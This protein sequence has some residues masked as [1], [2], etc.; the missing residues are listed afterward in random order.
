MLEQNKFSSKKFLFI[1]HNERLKNQIVKSLRFF[2]DEEELKLVS[3]SV[4][5]VKD[6]LSKFIGDEE[7]KSCFNEEKRLNRRRFKKLFAGKEIDIDLF[8]E[9]YRGILRGYNLHGTE[10]ILEEEIY[11]DE[12]GRR[13]GKVDL[14]LRE[15]FY[16]IAS[17]IERNLARTEDLD[18][19][20]GG[21]DDLD[22]CRYLEN[23]IHSGEVERCLD[24][25]YIDEVQDLTTAELD[26]FLQLL[27]PNGIQWF[28]AAGDLSQSVQPSAFTWE[29]LR[30][31]ITRI[32]GI[33]VREEY[34]LDENYRSTPHLVNA[35]NRILDISKEYSGQNKAHLQRPTKGENEGEPMYIFEKSEDE[36]LKMLE[37]HKL[38]NSDCLLLTRDE[39]TKRY[40]KSKMSEDQANFIETIARYKGLEDRDVI[41]W[42]PCSGSE[43]ILDLL[44]HPQRGE[45]MMKKIS[46]ITSG[47]LELNFLF[48]AL[49]RARYLLG[50]CAPVDNDRQHFLKYAFSSKDYSSFDSGEKIQTFGSMK[51]DR[52][53]YLNRAISLIE[54]GN[55]SAAS[56]TYR[57]IGMLHEYH[58]YKAEAYLEEEDYPRAVLEWSKTIESGET[59][60][61]TGRFKVDAQNQ[62][63]EY[64]TE[65]IEFSTNEQLDD[66]KVCIR[67][68][69]Y[70]I[71]PDKSRNKFKG[72]D[73]YERGKFKD[74]AQ[75]YYDADERD[76]VNK[77]LNKFAAE[78]A[79][80]KIEL[81]LLIDRIDEAEK[82]FKKLYK[83]KE[84]K[85]PGIQLALMSGPDVE[86]FFN[87]PFT[88]LKS[89]FKEIQIDW[90]KEIARSSS[91]PGKWLR[92]IDTI[93]QQ[94]I[95]AQ[96]P[97]N[98]EVAIQHLNIYSQNKDKS[99]MEQLK[100]KIQQSKVS[101]HTLQRI[102]IEYIR[103]F[104]DDTDILKL[105]AS[106]T[107]ETCAEIL[108]KFSKFIQ[109]IEKKPE[110]VAM[111][112]Q[113]SDLDLYKKFSSIESILI[114]KLISLSI[115]V[116]YELALGEKNKDKIYDLLQELLS[117]HCRREV[118]K[119]V[120]ACA[121]L[122]ACHIVDVDHPI[123]M[124]SIISLDRLKASVFKQLFWDKKFDPQIFATTIQRYCFHPQHKNAEDLNTVNIA[125]YLRRCITKMAK[126]TKHN[127][128][129]NCRLLEMNSSRKTTIPRFIT[130]SIDKVD[131]AD[132]NGYIHANRGNFS[133]YKMT[134]ENR[135][136]LGPYIENAN[137][138]VTQCDTKNKWFARLINTSEVY[139]TLWQ[140]V[141]IDEGQTQG[142][143]DEFDKIKLQQID[144]KEPDFETQ[145][146][147]ESEEDY[148]TEI[149]AE[150]TDEI[151]ELFDEEVEIL[152][153]EEETG[154][155]LLS[156]SFLT[157][158]MIDKENNGKNT[159]NRIKQGLIELA[160]DEP[161]S[162]SD[163][164]HIAFN[165][166]FEMSNWEK[167]YQFA[168][169]ESIFNL[170]KE[171]SNLSILDKSQKQTFRAF[172]NANHMNILI[173]QLI[174]SGR[175]MN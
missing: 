44:H 8:W 6:A 38:P 169:L 92:L 13:R 101:E 103:C 127:F 85:K 49:T 40:L 30:D 109:K 72:D 74:A 56:G 154:P 135:S 129:I 121:T 160:G 133:E 18:P 25:L 153:V 24:F 86:K 145:T 7:Y 107:S 136:F 82:E 65:A 132:I 91:D 29:S 17:T 15:E 54:N 139:R 62:I 124:K 117:D 137:K 76:L 27:N 138:L 58:F 43:N 80:K 23:K 31:L 63:A 126:D 147:I 141:F 55:L 112:L 70:S 22:V 34:R 28:A 2:F 149:P 16:S 173:T 50:V 106:S 120:Q 125:N 116:N 61:Q 64:S 41:L 33:H 171:R 123:K 12:L 77:C 42:D 3:E 162:A 89:R 108:G 79:I 94:R 165:S 158:E 53:H 51:M 115:L 88:K 37:E 134:K 93:V 45:Q 20:N 84:D 81:L 83:N 150:S 21:W 11:L 4:M 39:K 159:L 26:V 78:D 87:P 167:A 170:D 10:R 60:G 71:L 161:K 156:D 105:V 164:L 113:A 32:I 99:G 172:K 52:E 166:V 152:T 90:A 131:M 143:L 114:Q 14:S 140:S 96:P 69:A 110:S 67:I 1:T 157:A 68:H 168:V 151:I 46:N 155:K 59:E 163:F 119:T 175:V 36:L 104:G 35:A 144:S 66:V 5:S 100:Q 47:K 174:F 98:D 57:Q 128:Y 48:V 9:E 102:E 146:Q 95:L 142:T 19:K 122:I 118:Q 73:F 97:T 130:N 111:T 148:A 75:Y